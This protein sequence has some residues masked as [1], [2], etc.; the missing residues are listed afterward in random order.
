[1][2]YSRYNRRVRVQGGGPGSAPQAGDPLRAAPPQLRRRLPQP[3]TTHLSAFLPFSFHPRSATT[4]LCPD[5]TRRSITWPN[6]LPFPARALS[7]AVALAALD[8]SSATK[9]VPSATHVAAITCH[10]R[11]MPPSC[12]GCL[13]AMAL[14]NWTSLQ[15]CSAAPSSTVTLSPSSRLPRRADASARKRPQPD[16]PRTA[17]EHWRPPGHGSAPPP[18]SGVGAPRAS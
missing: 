3:S 7:P 2:Y 13:T 16:E 4:A 18:G 1:M 11:A 10:A 5:A 15:P 14:T 12:S 8:T 6:E 17:A 9:P